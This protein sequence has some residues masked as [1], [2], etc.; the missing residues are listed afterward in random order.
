VGFVVDNVTRESLLPSNEAFFV[1][2]HY[3]NFLYLFV[4][5]PEDSHR[6]TTTDADDDD[7]AEDTAG[8]QT[9]TQNGNTRHCAH[10]SESA[11]VR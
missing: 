8:Q 3:A 11:G 7:D 6:P 4:C 1:K 2:C 5:H 10:T 9:T